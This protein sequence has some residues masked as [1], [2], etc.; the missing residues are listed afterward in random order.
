MES[1]SP[2]TTALTESS[3]FL[4][5][6]V[7]DELAVNTPNSPTETDP[8]AVNVF[9]HLNVSSATVVVCCV[10]VAAARVNPDAATSVIRVV[11]VLANAVVPVPTAI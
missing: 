3:T 6:I 7:P 1:V 2:L 4:A 9:V 5:I 10:T 11:C 8:D